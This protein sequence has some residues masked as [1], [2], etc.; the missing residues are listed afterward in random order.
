[1]SVLIVEDD[2]PA[3]RRLLRIVRTHPRYAD[4]EIWCAD[5][6]AG[7]R[8]MLA[9][10]PVQLLLLDLEL[11]GADGFELLSAAVNAR[12]QIIVVSAHTQRAIEAFEVGVADFVPKPVSEARL[13]LALGRVQ[14]EADGGRPVELLVRTRVGLERV[15]VDDIV[16][17]Q[18]D[19]DYVQLALRSGRRLLHDE[20][21]ARLV[22]RLPAEFV[23]VH[24]SHIVRRDAVHRVVDGPSG[25]RIL[26]L[27]GGARVPVS[28]RRAAAVLRV[29]L[30]HGEA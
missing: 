29:V 17:I 23:R 19:D 15:S 11:H 22:R 30:G 21:L 7:A 27:A 8:R 28:R 12:L 3:Q 26:Q 4:A 2:L 25:T 5:D 9:N 24:R 10:Q 13:Q 16:H 20:P 1:M 14:P 18:A 6:L